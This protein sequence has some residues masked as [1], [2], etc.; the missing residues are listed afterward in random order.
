[1]PKPP[2]PVRMHF[3]HAVLLISALAAVS[4][5][6]TRRAQEVPD[7]RTVSAAA[8]P[9]R[10]AE[11]VDA[12]LDDAACDELAQR[13]NGSDPET[14]TRAA[15]LLGGV[16]EREQTTA[17][18]PQIAALLLERLERREA[19]EVRGHVGVD[20]VAARAL[21]RRAFM[22]GVAERLL[23]LACGDAPHPV[24]AVRTEC[25]AVVL[26]A[27]VGWIDVSATNGLAPMDVRRAGL[28]RRAAAFLLS[29]LRAETPDE[30]KSPRSWERVTTL[31]WVKTRAALALTRAAAAH[32]LWRET[33]GN[34]S[35]Q[36]AVDV[37]VTFRPDGSWAHQ[38]AEADRLEAILFDG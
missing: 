19:V 5:A 34:S 31:A 2:T 1:M 13:M 22:D 14:A 21:D 10:A 26:E 15:V 29:I 32:T 24:L 17:R 20:V 36:A 33:G 38:M 28:N 11:L 9:E 18:A 30:A 8:F 23:E 12:G 37:E 6:W 3:G 4:V 27:N 7:W 16:L 25:A 35:A